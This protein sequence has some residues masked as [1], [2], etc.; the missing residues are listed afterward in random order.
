MSN[1]YFNSIS[2]N[3]FRYDAVQ[4]IGDQAD[5]KGFDQSKREKKR[6]KF[7]EIDSKV[8]KLISLKLK[9]ISEQVMSKKKLNGSAILKSEEVIDTSFGKLEINKFHKS[10]TIAANKEQICWS[11]D[12]AKLL[13]KAESSFKSRSK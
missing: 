2:V 7:D 5:K 8:K 9:Q 4:A 3:S 1:F 11:E 12:F 6:E 10:K 13:F